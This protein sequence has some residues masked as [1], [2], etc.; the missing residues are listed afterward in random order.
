MNVITTGAVG[1]ISASLLGLTFFEQLSTITQP[2]VP[3]TF[4]ILTYVTG[5]LFLVYAL[6]RRYADSYEHRHNEERERLENR[7]SGESN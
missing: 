4:T 5:L 2:A 6:A 7:E 1:F 3:F